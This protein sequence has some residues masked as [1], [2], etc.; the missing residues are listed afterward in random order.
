MST[1]KVTAALEK[2]ALEVIKFV[3][4]SPP[5]TNPAVTGEDYSA[6]VI[7]DDRTYTIKVSWH[8]GHRGVPICSN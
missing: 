7:V 2:A 1:T 5:P 3:M 8:D 6:E 4:S